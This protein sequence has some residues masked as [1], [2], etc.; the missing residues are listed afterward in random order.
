[1]INDQQQ[2]AIATQAYLLWEQEGHPQGRSLDHWVAA[3][4]TI[5]AKDDA[6]V[7]AKPA[8]KTKKAKPATAKAKRAASTEKKS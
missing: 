2:H 3:E 6:P 7:I 1:M 5:L 8:R 4:R